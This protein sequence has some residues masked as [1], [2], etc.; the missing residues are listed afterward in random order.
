MYANLDNADLT[1]AN[2]EGTNITNAS[3]TT[4]ILTGA[5]GNSLVDRINAQAVE[6]ASKYWLSEIADLRPGSTMIEI[7]DGSALLSFRVQE[8]TD[9]TNWFDTAETSTVT[10]PAPSPGKKFFRFAGPE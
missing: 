10:V 2:L 5:F 4:T 9:L 8:T 7:I 6:I 3:M 1:D